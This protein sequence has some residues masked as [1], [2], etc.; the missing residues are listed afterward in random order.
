MNLSALVITECECGQV[1]MLLNNPEVY[2]S[3]KKMF[4]SSTGPLSQDLDVF[5]CQ[6]EKEKCSKCGRE[7]LLPVAEL[8]DLDRSEKGRLML[9]FLKRA[10]DDLCERF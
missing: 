4:A 6:Q 1:F 7:V 5:L 8:L 10:E 3:T 9:D 2:D